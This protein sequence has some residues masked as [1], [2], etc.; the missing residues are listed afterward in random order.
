MEIFLAL[1]A[2]LGYKIY[3]GRDWA[4]KT[5]AVLAILG[6]SIAIT[7][8][9]AGQHHEIVAYIFWAQTLLSVT[10]LALFYLL[11]YLFFALVFSGFGL[12]PLTEHRNIEWFPLTM[13]IGFFLFGIIGHVRT[14]ALQLDR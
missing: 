4:R 2:L 1:C 9:P 11:F 10:A 8:E 14:R 5:F 12:F 6:L 3:I 7:T 13:G